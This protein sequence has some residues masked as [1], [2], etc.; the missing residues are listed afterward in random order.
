MKNNLFTSSTSHP[1]RKFLQQL[2]ATM[3]FP[4]LST[5]FTIPVIPTIT[6]SLAPCQDVLDEKYWEMVKQQF[7]VPPNLV[8]VNAANLCP[9]PY[10]VNEQIMAETKQIATDVSFQNRAKYSEKRIETLAMLAQFLGVSS[11]E[12]GITRN[13]TESNNIIVNG[14]D[15]KPGD[16]VII[17]E[18]NHPTNGIAWKQRAKRYGFTVKEIKLPVAP[19]SAEDLMAPFAAAITPKTKMITF[20]HI[21]NVSGLALP[22]QE[23]CQMAKAKGIL[24]LVDG[25]QSLGFM[26]LNLQAIGCDFYTSSTHKWLMGPMENGILY[27]SKAQME[28]LWPNIIGAGW[29]ETYQTVD[30]KLCVLGQR[31][32][33]GTAALPSILAFHQTIGKKNIEN[34]VR[35]LCAYLKEQIQTNLPQAE[36][37]TPLS[38]ALCGGVVIISIPDKQPRELFQQMYED[39]GIACAPT[40]G[41]R[42]SPHIYNTLQDMDKIVEGLVSVSA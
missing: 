41:I 19:Q 28:K 1:R 23:I 2:G 20:S 42:L 35:Q 34:R 5:S 25:A 26:D 9:S 24:T 12:I 27:V 37:I 4:A 14:L 3:A 31:N 8:M 30:E 6:S 18:Q 11:E 33:P 16:E 29:E 13:T 36:F 22:A 21:S 32:D 10:F 38:P 15:F 40:G 39:H 7:T 17:W